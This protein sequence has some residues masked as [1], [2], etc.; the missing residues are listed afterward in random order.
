MLGEVSKAPAVTGSFP[1]QHGAA[2]RELVDDNEGNVV[3]G[4]RYRLWKRRKGK[5]RGRGK[6][7][8]VERSI[9][10]K[11]HSKN[12]K[13]THR[14]RNAY[15]QAK[16]QH[17]TSEREEHLEATLTPDPPRLS[18]LGPRTRT[19]E[20]HAWKKSRH[21]AMIFL[22]LFL[23]RPPPLPLSLSR[24]LSLPSSSTPSFAPP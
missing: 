17:A 10:R 2:G 15:G 18:C 9:Q 14:N 4:E 5:G 19:T 22:S 21:D 8:Q 3:H 13:L 7:G 16:R 12:A 6:Q 1:P 24:N 20:P 11:G 23:S